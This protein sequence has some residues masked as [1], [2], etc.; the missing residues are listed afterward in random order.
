MRLYTRPWSPG[1]FRTDVTEIVDVKA[2]LNYLMPL[3]VKEN[4]LGDAPVTVPR[5]PYVNVSLLSCC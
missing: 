1:L 2:L 5:S 3:K 4:Y